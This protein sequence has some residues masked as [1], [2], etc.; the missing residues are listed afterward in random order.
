MVDY[1]KFFYKSGE[2][3]GMVIIGPHCWSLV[4]DR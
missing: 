2:R 1:M 4:F 3:N